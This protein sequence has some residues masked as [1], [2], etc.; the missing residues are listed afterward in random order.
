M[1][2]QIEKPFE[3]VMRYFTPELVVRFNSPDDLEADRA[4]AEWEAAMRAYREHL[5]GLRARMPKQV[6]RLADLCLHDAEILAWESPIEPFFPVFE[7][8]SL[9]FPTGFVIFSVRQGHEIISLMYALA[10]PVCQYSSLDD[11]PFSSQRIHWLYDEIDVLADQ[12]G[13]FIHRVLLSDGAVVEI[14]FLSVLVHCFA[15]ELGLE[16]EVSRQIA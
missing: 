3:R 15:L 11:W 7:N 16:A 1:K 9:P 5:D 2:P 6:E 13:V 14:R 8:G 12:P 10:E 4:D